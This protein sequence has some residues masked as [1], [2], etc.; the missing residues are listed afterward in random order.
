[1]SLPVRF[2]G[3]S[4]L[5]RLQ[6]KI[7]IR[8]IRVSYESPMCDREVHHVN[9][10]RNQLADCSSGEIEFDREYNARAIGHKF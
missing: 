9:A 3:D 6:S 7:S 2:N 1:M 4:S 10:Q 5:W 8:M